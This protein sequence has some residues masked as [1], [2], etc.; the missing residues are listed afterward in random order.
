MTN[1]TKHLVS[2]E[3]REGFA[4]I[5]EQHMHAMMSELE[6]LLEMHDRYGDTLQKTYL[7][8]ARRALK[9]GL[10]WFEWSKK[11]A[12]EAREQA[13]RER[14]AARNRDEEIYGRNG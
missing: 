12:L 4:R 3:D 6:Q 13:A 9:D 10:D 11:R 14:L 8:K 1:P 2:P 5:L 7:Y